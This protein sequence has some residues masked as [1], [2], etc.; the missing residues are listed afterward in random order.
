MASSTRTALLAAA[1]AV[2]VE[3]GVNALS[4]RRIGEAAGLNPTLVTYHFGSLVNLL[5][6]LCT[7]NLEPIERQWQVIGTGDPAPVSLDAVLHAWLAPMLQPA[8]F[9][10]SGRALVVLDEL[11][12]H[13]EPALRA[14]ILG[15]MTSFAERLRGVLGPM[16]P[17]LDPPVL[18]S[19]LRFISGAALG[20][21]PRVRT[22]SP[23][24]PQSDDLAE[25]L[26]FA[27]AAL[28]P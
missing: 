8:A 10:D 20:P 16:L 25:L 26:A 2:L 19:R 18:R 17:G 11:A 21:P 5:D 14:R 22:P 7:H 12:A 24:G 27:R 28:R 3:Q 6:E 4:V 23:A 15:A 1:E 9:T 13:G